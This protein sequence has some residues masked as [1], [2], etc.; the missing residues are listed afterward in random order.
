MRQIIPDEAAAISVD[1]PEA[2]KIAVESNYRLMFDVIKAFDKQMAIDLLK[3]L[4]ERIENVFELCFAAGAVKD[5]NL[6]STVLWYK[7]LVDIE[8]VGMDYLIPIKEIKAALLRNHDS[9]V[10]KPGPQNAGSTIWLP[11][12]H[13]QYHLKQLEFYQRLKSLQKLVT[14]V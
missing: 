11:F 1:G 8:G 12:G 4:K 13:L 5:R 10:V 2:R 6:W 7:N 9:N 3:F 14:I